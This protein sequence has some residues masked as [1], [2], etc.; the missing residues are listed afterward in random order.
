MIAARGAKKVLQRMPPVGIG[1]CFEAVPLDDILVEAIRRL[2]REVGYFGVF[3]IEFL[4]LDR[5]MGRH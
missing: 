1:V 3:E 4:R 2:C 5:W